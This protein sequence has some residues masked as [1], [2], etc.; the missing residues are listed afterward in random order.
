MNRAC[1]T[2]AKQDTCFYSSEKVIDC[3]HH[4]PKSET[5]HERLFGTPERAARTLESMSLDS[6]IWCRYDTE[7]QLACNA[8]PYEFNPCGC[9]DLIPLLEWL[10]GDAE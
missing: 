8:C 2:C 5:N 4:E 6:S 9:Y 3:T 1:A 10:R 7:G